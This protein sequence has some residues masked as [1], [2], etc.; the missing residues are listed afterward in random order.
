MFYGGVFSQYPAIGLGYD[1]NCY[2]E[3]DINTNKFSILK[4]YDFKGY[5]K[6]L[7]DQLRGAV[8]SVKPPKQ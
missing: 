3:L 2:V 5:E 1:T 7:R 8:H 6:P 4:K